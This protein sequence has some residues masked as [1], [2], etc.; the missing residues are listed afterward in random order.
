[1]IAVNQSGYVTKGVKHATIAGAKHYELHDAKG[2][3]VLSGDV[4]LIHDENSGAEAG[5]I[6]F[7]EVEKAG[8]Y[9][10]TDEK[11]SQSARFVIGRKPYGDLYR[12]AMRM[13]YFQRC[14][15]ELTPEYAGKFA[16]KACHCME[17]RVLK[18]RPARRQKLLGGWHD[19]GDY[20]RYVTAGAV[21]L[22]HMLYAFEMKPKAFDVSLNIPESGSGI[23]DILSECAWELDWMLQMQEKDGGVHHKATSMH[24]ADFIMPE[25]D[26]L[27]PVMTP[28]SSLAT[29]DQAAVMALAS[30]IYEPYDKK[31]AAKYK[32]SALLA[33]KWLQANP[34]FLFK[35]PSDVHT[36]TY[37]DRCDADERLWAAAELYLLDG[38]DEW[39]WL[40]R[41]ILE[42]R[43]N[44]TALG[45]ADV[46]GL[47]AMAVLLSPAG[48]FP[49]DLRTRFKELW[50]EGADRLVTIASENPYELAF[51]PYEFHWGSNMQVLCNAMVLL[52]AHHLTKDKKYADYARFQLDYILGRNALDISYVTGHGERAF[53][54]PHNRPTVADG[55]EEVIPGFVSGGPNAHGGDTIANR[56]T[57]KGKAPMCCYADDWRSYSTN[58]ITIY[59]NSPLV[60]V[61]AYLGA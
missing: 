33:A 39:I 53:K 55:I 11:G 25:D 43:V 23:P 4:K 35:N 10:F 54:D 61:L 60:F 57:L 52:F 38:K 59:W 24:F 37:E 44:T 7:S 26:R 51:R 40:I 36:G 2:S 5:L 56:E 42:I 13:F 21:A 31:R 9:Y 29:A 3:V 20:G 41:Q 28:V 18:S 48:T 14:G 47:A 50:I 17:A 45:W 22:A 1:M 19:A 46:G 49:K 32:K 34:D 8:T 27:V 6:D 16:H 30:R 15:M 58:E 12:D